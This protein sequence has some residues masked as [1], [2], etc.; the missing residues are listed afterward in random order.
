VDEADRVDEDDAVESGG[1]E[2][3][4]GPIVWLGAM[5]IGGRGGIP[6]C[7]GYG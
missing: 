4:P 6:G 2:S 1:V 5:A 3:D 7:C